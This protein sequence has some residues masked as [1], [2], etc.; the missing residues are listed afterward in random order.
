MN[1]RRRQVRQVID[2][3]ASRPFDYEGG[4]C[5]RFVAAVVAAVSGVDPMADLAYRGEDAALGLIE[6]LGGLERA[7]TARL[8]PPTRG[9]VDDGYVTLHENGDGSLIAGIVYRGRS[10]VRS[11]YSVTD[12]DLDTALAIWKT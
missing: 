11:R 8:G 3:W 4:D 7:I 9:A 10:L 2:D 5:C 1:E 6:E 12:W